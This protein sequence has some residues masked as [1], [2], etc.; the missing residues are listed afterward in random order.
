MSEETKDVMTKETKEVE[1]GRSQS[2]IPQAEV[3]GNYAPKIMLE[4][5]SAG[6]AAVRMLSSFSHLSLLL[7][8]NCYHLS[9]FYSIILLGLKK[10]NVWV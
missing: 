1:R 4:T 8:I 7:V 5:I 2:H 6:T 3:Y 9:N 10:H